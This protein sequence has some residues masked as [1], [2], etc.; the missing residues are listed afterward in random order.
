MGWLSWIAVGLVAGLLAKWIMPGDQEAGFFATLGLGVAGAFV[1]GWIMSLI[2]GE[3]IT[4]FNLPS[5]LVATGGAIVVLLIYGFI[6]K[7]AKS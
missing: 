6:R 4:G 1:G 7:S 3:G 5:L 2:T